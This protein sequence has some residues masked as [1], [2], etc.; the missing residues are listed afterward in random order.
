MVTPSWRNSPLRGCVLDL[1]APKGAPV[2]QTTG[3]KLGER[4]FLAK[5]FG[6]APIGKRMHIESG[7]RRGIGAG[8]NPRGADQQKPCRHVARHG[9]AK[10][11]RLLR[12]FPVAAMQ[13]RE[14]LLLFPELLNHRLHGGRHESRGIIHGRLG[15]G[16]FRTFFRSARVKA[17]P[18]EKKCQ[19][20][21]HEDEEHK[22]EPCGRPTQ[23]QRRTLG[24]HPSCGE[25]HCGGVRHV[26]MR[27]TNQEQANQKRPR[28]LPRLPEKFQ[29]AARNRVPCARWRLRPRQ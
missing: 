14:L 29:K 13:G 19:R 23:A 27:G 21:R 22:H 26:R 5:H 17:A 3:Q 15:K 18:N 1:L 12:P 8:N 16:D 4:R 10:P 7:L 2:R 25:Y 24:I 28:G 11:L 6:V 9:F 20:R